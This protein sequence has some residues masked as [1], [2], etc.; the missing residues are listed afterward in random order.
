LRVINP[1]HAIHSIDKHR[2][3]LDD[4]DSE[5]IYGSGRRLISDRSYHASGRQKTIRVAVNLVRHVALHCV[6]LSER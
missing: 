3:D 5:F 6:K 4:L 1:E 2:S